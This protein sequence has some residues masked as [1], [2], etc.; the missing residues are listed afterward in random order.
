MISPALRLAVIVAAAA[1]TAS[2]FQ[3][4]VGVARAAS[5][6]LPCLHAEPET[7]TTTPSDRRAFLGS[8]AALLLATTTTTTLT[9]GAAPSR[10]H[11]AAAVDY[12]AVA[13]DVAGLL[14]ANPDWGPTFVRL[15]WHSSGK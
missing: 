8:S 1:G 13:S 15:A 9:L 12:K 5:K 3:P 10:V 6:S 7:T 2:A 4:L 14:K 11:A